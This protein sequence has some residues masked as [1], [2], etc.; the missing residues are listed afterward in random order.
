MIALYK[1]IKEDHYL[2]P[3]AIVELALIYIDQGNKDQAILA[4]EDAK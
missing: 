3:Y 4:L 1:D 2:V